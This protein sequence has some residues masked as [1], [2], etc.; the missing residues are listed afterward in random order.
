MIAAASSASTL[1]LAAEYLQ[2]YRQWRNLYG[3][4][5]ACIEELKAEILEACEEPSMTIEHREKLFSLAQLI[6]LEQ[7]MDAERAA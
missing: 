1:D 5:D 2:T 6:E 7:D 3:M 4:A